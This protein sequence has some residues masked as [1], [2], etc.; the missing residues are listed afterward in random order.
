MFKQLKDLFINTKSQMSVS[1]AILGALVI[2]SGSVSFA[3]FVTE[4]TFQCLTFACFAYT[5][6]GDIDGLEQH[7]ALVKQ[8]DRRGSFFIKWVGW[9]SPLFYPAYLD[10]A[11]ANKAYILVMERVITRERSGEAEKKGRWKR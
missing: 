7:L 6:S 5:N 4:E 3:M 10:Y 2:V 1:V 11:K 8:I 9:L